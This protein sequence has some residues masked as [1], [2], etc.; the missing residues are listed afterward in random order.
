MTEENAA[1]VEGTAAPETAELDQMAAIWD[2]YQGEA[3]TPE[4]KAPEETAAEPEKAEEAAPETTLAAIEAPTDLPAAI[5]AKWAEIPE[6]ARDAVLAS[7]RAMAG[8]LTE[9]GRVTQAAKPVYDVLVQAAR[10]IPSMQDMTPAQIAADVFEMAK[11]QH[12]L[13]T[14][15]VGTL[16]QIAQ[17]HGALQGLAARLSGQAVDVQAGQSVVLAKHLQT[18]QEQIAQLSDP[19]KVEFR[20]EQALA[21]REVSRTVEEYASTKEHWADVEPILPQFIEI[22]QQGQGDGASAKDI[23]DAAY[24]MAIHA[25]PALRAKVT[26][27]TAPATDPRLTAAQMKAK[28]VNVVSRPSGQGRPLTEREAMEAVWDKYRAS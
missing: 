3:E 5:K 18:L 20:V 26:A 19:A 1:P 22:A 6:S 2:K 25:I 28:S 17:Q 7:H 24:D 11:V 4:E 14:D 21:Q 27:A 16:L 10:E 23:L 15:P 9:Q 13:N 12:A 8:K